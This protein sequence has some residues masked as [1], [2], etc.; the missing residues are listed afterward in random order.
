MTQVLISGLDITP[1]FQLNDLSISLGTDANGEQKMAGECAACGKWAGS[2][3]ARLSSY[4]IM[5]RTDFY[6]EWRRRMWERS[7]YDAALNLIGMVRDEPTTL[8][9]VAKYYNAEVGDMVWEFSQLLR[10]WKAVTLTY[11]FEE[12]ILGFAEARGTEQPCMIPDEI[13]PYLGNSV[14]LQSKMFLEY[15]DFAQRSKG[16]LQR[17]QLPQRSESDFV[18]SMRKG[19]LRADGVV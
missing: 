12:R 10:G 11:G 3:A 7:V 16:L 5:C 9:D 19:N 8:A 17:V 1:T 6:R 14:F 2:I 13:Y 4:N 15:M 18:S